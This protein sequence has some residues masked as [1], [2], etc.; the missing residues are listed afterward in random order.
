MSD[1]IPEINSSTAMSRREVDAMFDSRFLAFENKIINLLSIS[2]KQSSADSTTVS[3]DPP[4]NVMAEDDDAC[5]FLGTESPI[6]RRSWQS[7]CTN[8]SSRNITHIPDNVN[9][10]N[11]T[12]L[13]S[14]VTNVEEDEELKSIPKS[15]D[16]MINNVQNILDIK[17]Q[18]P[19]EEVRKSSLSQSFTGLPTSKKM[20]DVPSLPAD[21]IIVNAWKEVEKPLQKIAS[22]KT[23]H[24][25]QYRWPDEYFDKIG[26]SPDIDASVNT[27]IYTNKGIKRAL[28]NCSPLNVRQMLPLQLLIKV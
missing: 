10:T 24:R 12:F 13:H 19:K 3:N 20:T 18:K 8:T 27:Y 4:F 7:G 11:E 28:G 14:N 23:C 22:F 1:L 2:N 6:K 16:N 15:W 21:G 17:A 5:S 26:K 25:Y 9:V